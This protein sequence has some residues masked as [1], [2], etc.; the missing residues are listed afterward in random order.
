MQ[1][2][3]L[4]QG[5]DQFQG[6]TV[7]E[8]VFRKVKAAE[9]GELPNSFDE[10]VGSRNDLL[11]WGEAKHPEATQGKLFDICQTSDGPGKEL[12]RLRNLECHL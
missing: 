12:D 10:L 9:R 2:R 1:S 7:W 5:F 3:K 4:G 8:V 11:T 6:N